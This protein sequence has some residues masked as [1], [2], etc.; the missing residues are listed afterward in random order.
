[1]P[2]RTGTPY[3]LECRYGTV[4]ILILGTLDK[5]NYRIAHSLCING[6]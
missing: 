3:R 6:P 2:V 4:P 1:M 5:T